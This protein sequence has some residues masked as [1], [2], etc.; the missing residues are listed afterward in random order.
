MLKHLAAILVCLATFVAVTGSSS[1]A[2][3]GAPTYSEHQ[4]LTYYLG[5]SGQKQPVKTKEDWQ[6]RRGHILANLHKVMGD[7]PRPEKPV[8]LDMQVLE[9]A[10]VGDLIRK[11][12]S[13]HTDSAKRIVT[14]YLFLPPGDAKLPAV[15]SLR[16]LLFLRLCP[17]WPD[18]S[19]WRIG[20][21]CWPLRMAQRSS[22][23]ILIRRPT[24]WC[25]YTTLLPELSLEAVLLATFPLIFR[26]LLTAPVSCSGFGCSIP[27]LWGF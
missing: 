7:L 4:D 11:K 23:L 22:A 18:V 9:E 25:L 1:D 19:I 10:N 26:Y 17:H 16:R 12:I 14:A 6:I 5:D 27:G 2:A 8:P 15:L 20:A 21:N 3:D 13:Y 24:G